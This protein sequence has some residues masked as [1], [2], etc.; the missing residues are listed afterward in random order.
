M[1]RIFVVCALICLF[2]VAAVAQ[3]NKPWTEWTAKD[4]EKILNDSAWGQ[5][6]TEES[7]GS[8]PSQTS[9]ISSTTAAKE[10][11]VRVPMRRLPAPNRAKRK[12]RRDSLS[13]AFSVG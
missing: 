10:K 13:R 11:N 7:G 8:Q 3:K 1:K 4:A 6:Q 2:A 5:T 12:R 9:A